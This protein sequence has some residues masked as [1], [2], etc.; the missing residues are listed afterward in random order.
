ML[1]EH[2]MAERLAPTHASRAPPDL[3]RHVV[4]VTALL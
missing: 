2:L 3:R 1:V 4:I